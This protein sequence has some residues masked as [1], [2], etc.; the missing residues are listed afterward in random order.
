MPNVLMIFK[1][2]FESSSTSR[3]NLFKLMCVGEVLH[4][5][6]QCSYISYTIF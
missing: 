5:M 4:Y 2:H 6:P 1:F 3:A